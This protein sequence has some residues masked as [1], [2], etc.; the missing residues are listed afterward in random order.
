MECARITAVLDAGGYPS[1]A[2]A[3]APYW[4]VLRAAGVQIGAGPGA[5]AIVARG[6]SPS[7]Q[8]VAMRMSPELSSTTR[9]VPSARMARPWAALTPV[10][11]V[12]TVPDDK[13]TALIVPPPL[14]ATYA[15]PLLT[16]TSSVDAKCAAAVT[17]PV[18]GFTRSRPG[19]FSTET[20][21]VPSPAGVASTGRPSPVATVTGPPLNGGRGTRSRLPWAASG[22]RSIPGSTPRPSTPRPFGVSCT[23]SVLAPVVVSRTTTWSLRWFAS[24]IVDEDSWTM[25]SGFCRSAKTRTTVAAGLSSVTLRP[26]TLLTQTLPLLSTITS[27]A[28]LTRANSGSEPKLRGPGQAAW[29]RAPVRAAA[30]TK[31]AAH[32]IADKASPATA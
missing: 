23:H 3:A 2:W 13:S 10:T 30:A 8:P 27:S 17:V 11:R 32:E 4:A 7:Q 16:T 28:F 20:S 18:T 12:L 19:G 24:A 29:P 1:E 6:A 9:N 22:R 15:M 25:P 14:S 5:A 31:G 26:P 21:S